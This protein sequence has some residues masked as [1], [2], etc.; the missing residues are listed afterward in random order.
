M[1]SLRIFSTKTDE[2]LSQFHLEAKKNNIK[3]SIYRYE[4]FSFEDDKLIY[5]GRKGFP[6]FTSEDVVLFRRCAYEKKRQ[7]FWLRLLATLA[8]DSGAEVI[9]EDFMVNF[10]LHSGKL[11]QAAYFSAYKIPH[12]STYRLSRKVKT[13]E[14]PLLTKKRYT[15]FGK[16]S[17]LL[18]N[19]QDLINIKKQIKCLDDFVVQP[20]LELERDT[21]VL[22]LDKKIVGA[23]KRVVQAKKNGEIIVKV[24]GTE[25]LTHAEKD[26]MDKF[27]DVFSLDLAGVDLFTSKTGKT[28]L[29]EINFFPNFAG[30]IRVTEKNLFKDILEMMAKR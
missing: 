17:Y 29:G 25:E 1:K 21:R 13:S 23:V 7:H 4:N 18:E 10:P 5:S 22:I 6:S 14:Y 3:V 30:Y 20:F 15:A 12:I 26:I 28:W 2:Y 27:L 16:D 24:I 11:F 8:R 9:N 19:H